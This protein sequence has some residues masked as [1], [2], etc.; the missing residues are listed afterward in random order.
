MLK[1]A[2]D[3]HFSEDTLNWRVSR[4]RANYER[5]RT[6]SALMMTILA[7]DATVLPCQCWLC[8]IK[9]YIQKIMTKYWIPETEITSA[10][11]IWQST[12]SYHLWEAA[13]WPAWENHF[14]LCP[15]QQYYDIAANVYLR[16]GRALIRVM[17]MMA[18]SW[19]NQTR[20][21]GATPI[22]Y[23]NQTHRD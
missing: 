8:P 18:N 11:A 23:R 19:V 2:R 6:D 4:G 14:V 20:V 7:R 10:D 22:T 3:E 13:P 15:N 12:S 21:V 9:G 16:A 5:E 17:I 1:Y